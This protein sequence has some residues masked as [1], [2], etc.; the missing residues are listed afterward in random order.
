MRGVARAAPLPHLLPTY[1]LSTTKWLCIYLH[2]YIYA[3]GVLKALLKL[4]AAL[5]PLQSA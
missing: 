1:L 3:Q 5:N 2:I 4:A